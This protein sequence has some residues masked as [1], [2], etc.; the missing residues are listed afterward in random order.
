MYRPAREAFLRGIVT[1][2]HDS[3]AD[4]AMSKLGSLASRSRRSS[5]L[6]AAVTSAPCPIESATMLSIQDGGSTVPS[7]GRT[8]LDQRASGDQGSLALHQLM[9]TY[10]GDRKGDG[11]AN[12]APSV[13]LGDQCEPFLHLSQTV[14]NPVTTFNYLDSCYREQLDLQ[15]Q[16]HPT[17]INY[18]SGGYGGQHANL[19]DLQLSQVQRHPGPQIDYLNGCATYH[20]SQGF[21]AQEVNYLDNTFS[22]ETLRSDDDIIAFRLGRQDSS[23]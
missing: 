8:A 17:Q 16:C 21:P 18:L 6:P 4:D 2:R 3:D 23:I 9:D 19:P 5:T 22:G 13:G 7:D 20:P 15:L 12:T 14:E 10:T 1:D 11:G